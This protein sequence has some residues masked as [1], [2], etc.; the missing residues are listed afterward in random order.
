MTIR[1]ILIFFETTNL[2]YTRRKS[3]IQFIFI[4]HYFSYAYKKIQSC[5]EY[6]FF[7]FCYL[8]PENL[9]MCNVCIFS[10]QIFKGN[11][12][13]SKTF[14]WNF[15]RTHFQMY[16]LLQYDD[17]AVVLP[18]HET[19]SFKETTII[20]NI[21]IVFVCVHMCSC[22]LIHYL[23]IF[24]CKCFF[25][26]FLNTKVEEKHDPRTVGQISEKWAK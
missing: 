22:I 21:F 18:S 6:L 5:F 11:K 2:L 19:Y 4:S 25:S 1:I 24:F 13:I 16:L 8:F 12:K 15:Y 9:L 23:S 26:T 17:A 10:E 20:N 3:V 14:D 7:F